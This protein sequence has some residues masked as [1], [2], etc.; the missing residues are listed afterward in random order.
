[1]SAN[2]IL[3]LKLVESS[4]FY[5]WDSGKTYIAII[6]RVNFR[7]IF[8]EDAEF[9]DMMSIYDTSESNSPTYCLLKIAE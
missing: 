8:S 2:L 7:Y 5:L 3:Q 4:L 6:D 1:M 9:L